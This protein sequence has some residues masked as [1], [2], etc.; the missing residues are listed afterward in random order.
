MIKYKPGIY[1]GP[2]TRPDGEFDHNV[3]LIK[4]IYSQTE[5]KLYGKMACI[6]E[7]EDWESNMSPIE[8]D[9]LIAP[10]VLSKWS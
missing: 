4:E 3:L 1:S 2:K 8:T 9:T 6:S 10:W 5:D 7:R